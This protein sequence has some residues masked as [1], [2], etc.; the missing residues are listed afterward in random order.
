[1]DWT[2][3]NQQT[4]GGDRKK[5]GERNGWFVCACVC[6]VEREKTKLGSDLTMIPPLYKRKIEMLLQYINIKSLT[7]SEVQWGPWKHFLL[8]NHITTCPI[9]VYLE[10]QWPILML[11]RPA[12]SAAQMDNQ[13]SENFL[14]HK[15]IEVENRAGERERAKNPSQSTRENPGKKIGSIFAL[16]YCFMFYFSLPPGFYF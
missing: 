4:W 9:L 3:H 12:R 14:F 13:K 2:G 8:S 15:L 6:M 11:H 16:I 1:M 5:T 10:D 7:R